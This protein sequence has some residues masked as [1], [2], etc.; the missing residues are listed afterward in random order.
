MSKSKYQ[1]A[2]VRGDG[3]GPEVCDSAVKVV[4]QAV[5]ASRLD[6][7]DLPAG[8]EHYR[9]TGNAL[10]EETFKACAGADAGVRTGAVTHAFP[11]S[12]G[13]VTVALE[14]GEPGWLTLTVADDGA[15]R[16]A[17]HQ[18]G[19]LGASIV[20]GLVQQLKATL[21]VS[22]DGGTRCTVRLP[23]PARA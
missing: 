11:S 12:G 13:S 2:V 20:E 19:S 16:G 21:A 14:A 23:A 10:P 3:I 9:K 22:N 8:A 5:G 17:V 6:L 7:V 15:G 18:Q 4:V 1:I